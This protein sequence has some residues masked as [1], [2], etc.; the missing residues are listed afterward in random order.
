MTA[1]DSERVEALDRARRFTASMRAGGA[2][3]GVE[4]HLIALD[5]E[6]TRLTAI[7]TGV[8]QGG[9]DETAF[10]Y[11]SRL[12]SEQAATIERQE[13]SLT[14]ERDRVIQAIRDQGEWEPDQVDEYGRVELA[15]HV[16]I[17]TRELAALGSQRT[18]G[19]G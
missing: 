5:D 14:D 19:Q 4:D 8:K 6:V 2:C 17:G 10:S 12:L 15:G 11:M 16:T 1:T 13:R 3:D 7:L 18:E 9:D